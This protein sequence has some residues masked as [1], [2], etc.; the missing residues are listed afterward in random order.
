MDRERWV[1]R[2][3]AGT[4]YWDVETNVGKTGFTDDIFI[5]LCK[6]IRMPKGIVTLN[7]DFSMQRAHFAFIH[8]YLPLLGDFLKLI[9]ENWKREHRT[10]K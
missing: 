5:S 1:S 6:K 2:L 7:D 3:I 10:L 9:Y 8:F 4:E